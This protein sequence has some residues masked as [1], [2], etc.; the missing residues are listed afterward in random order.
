VTD[1][2]KYKTEYP[3]TKRTFDPNSYQQ[4]QVKPKS[5]LN[6]FLTVNQ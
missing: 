5:K 6:N 4:A 3:Y 2:S 1:P